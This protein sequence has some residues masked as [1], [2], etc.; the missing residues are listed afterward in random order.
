MSNAEN[1]VRRRRRIGRWRYALVAILVF[2]GLSFVSVSGVRAHEEYVVD[3]REDVSLVAFY[4]DALTDPGV[5]GPLLLVGALLAVTLSLFL[6]FRPFRLDV[7]SFRVAMGEYRSYVPWLLRISFGIPLIGAGFGGYFVSPAVEVD[8]RLLQVALGFLLL[9]GL[10]TRFVALLTL[11]VYVVG[12]IAYPTLLLQ[13]ELVGGMIALAAVGGGRPSGDHV[14]LRLGSTPGTIVNRFE[15]V[16]DRA[17]SFQARTR[18]ATQYLPTICR[19]GLGVTFV[20]L[21]ATQ[22]LLD[23]GL[24][25]AV[26][27]HYD[28]TGVVPVDPA[29]WVLGAGLTEVALGLALLAGAFTRGVAV[30]ALVVFT[31]TLFALPDDPVLAHV[32]LY[33]LASVLLITG[34][35]PY[36]VDEVLARGEPTVRVP[37]ASDADTA[38]FE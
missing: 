4:R 19:L 7:L 29:L 8:V 11:G 6:S 27:D 1:G 16:T 10:G 25:L 12:V 3:D 30:T 31:V 26:V 34:G 5:I 9:F 17:A 15:F 33:G 37:P 35:G 18:P 22:K 23:P 13:L 14:L 21:G 20:Y 38:V 36:S 28:L 32:G 24:A 2:L